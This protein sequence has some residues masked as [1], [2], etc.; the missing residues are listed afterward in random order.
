MSLSLPKAALLPTLCLGQNI[1]EVS[2]N[3]S[4]ELPENGDRDW[5]P[6]LKRRDGSTVDD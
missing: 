1:L 5:H 3:F 2:Y 6:K 4:W